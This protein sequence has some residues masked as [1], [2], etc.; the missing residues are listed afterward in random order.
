MRAKLRPIVRTEGEDASPPAPHA[1]RQTYWFEPEI[2]LADP[3]RRD[4][5]RL[6][7]GSKQTDGRVHMSQIGAKLAD[8]PLCSGDHAGN[9]GPLVGQP[10]HDIPPYP[11]S[12]S[13]R[14]R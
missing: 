14:S 2:R 4:R 9:L 6:H 5:L 13:E 8:L 11:F 3:L 12:I 7:C 10:R 1:A